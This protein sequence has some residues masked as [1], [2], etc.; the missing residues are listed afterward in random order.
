MFS[1]AVE[2]NMVSEDTAKSVK[3]VKMIPENNRR[4]NYLGK[5]EWK[6]L[7]DYCAVH[8]KPVVVTA[9]NTGMKRGEIFN[10]TW[11]RVDL[12]HEFILLD[13]TKNGEMRE[14]PISGPLRAQ[15]DELAMNNVDGHKH[16]FHD[17]NGKRYTDIKKFFHSA[18][19]AAGIV[20]FHFHDLRHT[21]ASHLVVDGMDIPTVKDLL[22]HKTLAMTMRYAHLAPEH[23]AK[24]VK[25]LDAIF[26]EQA[27]S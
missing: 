18:C 26:R 3:R 22:G 19:D 8:L 25:I 21:F 15:L 24:A 17:K 7:V 11:D 6:R 14:I 27:L 12:K 4:L 10:L 1:K 9:L 20:N 2:W 5:D 16:V 13:I 23:K